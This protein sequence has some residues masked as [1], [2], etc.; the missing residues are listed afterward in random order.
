MEFRL[1]FH[2]CGKFHKQ[3]VPHTLDSFLPYLRS[4]HLSSIR[5]LT[6]LHLREQN[7][8]IRVL[9][10]QSIQSLL[11]CFRP[12]NVT[13]LDENYQQPKLKPF[14]NEKINIA[15]L[16]LQYDLSEI[17]KIIDKNDVGLVIFEMW[18][19]N[20]IGLIVEKQRDPMMGDVFLLRKYHLVKVR[21]FWK[22]HKSLN[23]SP[24]WFD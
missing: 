1:G 4:T 23:Q 8:K 16:L 10:A 11:F 7:L 5:F 19:Q 6:E 12:M 13:F 21:T 18:F 20:Q 9:L 17:N 22:G 3:I 24:T 14:L 2:Q 15:N